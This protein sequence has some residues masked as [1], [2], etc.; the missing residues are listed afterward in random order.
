M[1]PLSEHEHFFT[2]E[3]PLKLKPALRARVPALAPARGGWP[4][5]AEY[6]VWPPAATAASEAIEAAADAK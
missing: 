2:S 4:G 3:R 1:L 5:A 6:T